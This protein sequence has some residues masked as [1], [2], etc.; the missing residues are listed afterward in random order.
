MMVLGQRDSPLLAPAESARSWGFAG[1][2]AAGLSAFSMWG[3]TVDD[4]LISIRY[5]R[6]LAHGDGYRFNVPGP[7]TDGV[8]PLPWPFL[9]APLA[10]TDALGVLARAQLVGVACSLV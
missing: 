7:V 6:H 2:V 10:G 9:L 3:F 5:A 1:F 4:A 8:T